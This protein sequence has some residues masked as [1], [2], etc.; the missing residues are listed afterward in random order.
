[1]A[2]YARSATT[3]AWQSCWVSLLHAIA[4][5][6]TGPAAGDDGSDKITALSHGL[7]AMRMSL[8]T[9]IGQASSLDFLAAREKQLVVHEVMQTW[10]AETL[11]ATIRVIGVNM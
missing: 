3:I 6:S 1:M 2:F 10:R 9:M 4:K 5:E 7:A 11:V 8:D